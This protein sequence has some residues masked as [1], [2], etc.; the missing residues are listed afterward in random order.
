MIATIA[1]MAAATLLYRL[2]GTAASLV[3][4]SRWDVEA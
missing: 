3:L 4:H 1:S 2:R